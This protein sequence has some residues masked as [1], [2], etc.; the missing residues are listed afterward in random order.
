MMKVHGS[1]VVVNDKGILFIGPSGAG[2]SDL[3]LRLLDGGATLIADDYT[4]VCV[5]DGHAILSPPKEIEGM[6]EVRGVGLM[7]VPFA[8]DIQLHF[9]FDLEQFQKIERMPIMETLSYEEVEIPK[10][11]LDPFMA[12]ATAI[13]RMVALNEIIGIENE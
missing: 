11:S 12:S 7:K 5:Q 3:A 6:L 13:V 4:Q 8:R 10:Y 1:S 2:K 9:V